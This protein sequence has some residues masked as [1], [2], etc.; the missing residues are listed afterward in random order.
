MNTATATLNAYSAATAASAR[1]AVRKA[2]WRRHQRAIALPAAR[3]D[4][5]RF[6]HAPV[7]LAAPFEPAAST[8]LLSSDLRFA[9]HSFLGALTFITVYLF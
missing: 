3:R 7:R 5:R 1:A 6:G 4:A 8:A 2:E 9:A